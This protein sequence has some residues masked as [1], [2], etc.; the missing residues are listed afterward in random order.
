MPYELTNQGELSTEELSSK[1]IQYS[2]TNYSPD[3]LL[4]SPPH[5]KAPPFFLFYTMY[6]DIL[7]VNHV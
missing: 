5:I 4:S 6:E 2:S 3:F 1:Q 7:P